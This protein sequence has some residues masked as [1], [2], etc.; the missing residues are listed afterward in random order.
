LAA[1]GF[2]AARLSK[3]LCG[4]GEADVSSAGEQSREIPG[5]EASSAGDEPGLDPVS[6]DT[7]K[8]DERAVAE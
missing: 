4:T 3:K 8:G 1:E 2:T 5:F 6:A 7:D